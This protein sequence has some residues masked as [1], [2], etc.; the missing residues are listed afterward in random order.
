MPQLQDPLNNFLSISRK[1]PNQVYLIVQKMVNLK[2]VVPLI[3]HFL[4]N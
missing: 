2:N 3:G 1:V 4:T